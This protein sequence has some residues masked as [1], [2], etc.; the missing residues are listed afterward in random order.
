MNR[1]RYTLCAM[2]LL[3]A[4]SAMAADAAMTADKQAVDQACAADAATA[5][6][7]GETAGKGLMKCLEKYKKANPSWKESESCTA[8]RKE[9]H[10]Q[11]K[12]E[13]AA[14]GTTTH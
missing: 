3:S 9:M 11:A 1:T 4:T 2:L 10:K 6:C 13:K 7:G 14:K 8:A 12:A 5:G